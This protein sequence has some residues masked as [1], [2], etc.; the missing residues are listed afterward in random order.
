MI[1]SRS[2]NLKGAADASVSSYVI[3][4]YL[5]LKPVLTCLLGHH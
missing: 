3:Q 1:F 4:Y 5:R 2:D